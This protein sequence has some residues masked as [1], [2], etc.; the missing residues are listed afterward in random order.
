[1][2]KLVFIYSIPRETATKISDWTSDSSGVKLKKTK[3]GRCDDKVMAMYDPKVGGLRN[4]ISY[5]PWISSETGQPM[6]D[7]NG[8][9][10]TLQDKMEQKWNK[11]KGYFANTPPARGY[12][13]DGS[14]L[15]FF[16]TA[17]WRLKDGCTVLD[18]NNM[19]DEIGYYVMLASSLVA[20][21]ERE[22]RE[23]KWPKAKFY[24]A[25]ENESEELKY[26][27]NEIKTKAY[28]S[29]HDSDFTDAYKRKF[30]S[31]LDLA[32][33]RSSLSAQQVMNILT[34]FIE[35]S[36][37]TPGSN[38]ERFNNLFRMLSTPDGRERLEAMWILKQA[39]DLRIIYER[40]GTY[41]WSRAN[42]LTPL[43]LG[44]RYEDA[45]DFLLNPAKSIELEELSAQI[46]SK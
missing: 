26:K 15:P 8:K 38:I 37:F 5:T 30:V 39:M 4:Y 14:D 32:P 17:V 24:I 20:N 22:W 1:M 12:K 6:K 31:L 23:H 46:K 13:G 19:E 21:S 33:A 2:S 7:E 28:A 45:V 41:T 44:D 42:S 34:E 3:I 16:Q 9:E 10:L 11:P 29:L 36:G 40:Q 18:L 43:V 35:K 25:L 27:R